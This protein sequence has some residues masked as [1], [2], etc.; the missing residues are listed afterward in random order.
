MPPQRVKIACNNRVGDGIKTRKGKF[1]LNR[2]IEST[3]LMVQDVTME[4]PLLF[5]FF[6][7]AQ[8][9]FVYYFFLHLLDFLLPFE[10]SFR[11]RIYRISNAADVFTG[12][13]FVPLPLLLGVHLLQSFFFLR[14]F[15]ASYVPKFIFVSCSARETADRH[16]LIT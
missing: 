15:V 2:G 3:I 8:S 7:L 13:F 5:L 1:R 6:P 9:T 16:V 4:I 11:R 14:C 12:I 10:R